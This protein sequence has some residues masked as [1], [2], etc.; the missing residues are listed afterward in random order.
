MENNDQMFNRFFE[1]Y[2]HR[3][4][5]KYI[6]QVDKDTQTQLI[7]F[8]SSL[9]DQLSAE[10]SK[11]ISD[12]KPIGQAIKCESGHVEI[13]QRLLTSHQSIIK[14]NWLN[15]QRID[16]LIERAE[17]R[18]SPT[19]EQVRLINHYRSIRKRFVVSME[20]A[21]SF[22]QNELFKQVAQLE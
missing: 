7:K 5:E 14:A 1:K 15:I 16:V 3:T 9:H 11:S 20:H 17:Q 8:Y 2:L 6:D 19:A 13:V 18:L 4:L 12:L 21:Q 22:C 10:P